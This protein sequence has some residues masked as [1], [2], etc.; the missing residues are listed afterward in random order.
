MVQQ[1]FYL[2][3][4]RCTGCKTCVIACK[5]KYDLGPGISPRKVYECTGGETLRDDAGCFSTTCFN[6]YISIACNHCTDPVCVQVCPTMAMRKDE[7]TGLVTVDAKRCIGCGYCHL[8]CP[9]NAPK[10]DR[11]KGRSVKCDGCKDRVAVGEKPAC[12]L[13]CPARALAFGPVSEMS[14]R[15]ERARIAPL[16]D[17]LATVPNLFIKASRDARPSGSK[18]VAIANPLE[19]G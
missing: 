10:V 18:E 13:A 8:S 5:D 19:V 4:T 3:G 7:G 16:P 15:G 17:P 9:Y 1:A 2:D 14:D 11:S 12:V 6:Y